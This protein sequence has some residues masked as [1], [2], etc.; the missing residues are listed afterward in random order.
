VI[1]VYGST[2]TGGIAWRQQHTAW[3]LFEGMALN[4]IDDNW[5]LHSPYLD[6][7]FSLDDN[8]SLQTDGQFML[9]GRKD[10]IV[11]IEEKRLS[12]TE[13]E[14]RLTE[15]PQIADAFTIPI[16]KNRDRVGAAIVLTEAGL[17]QLASKGRNAFIKQLRTSLYQWFDATVLPRKWLVLNSIPLTTQGK[18]NQPLI[19]ALLDTDTQKLP[20]VQSVSI[21]ANSVELTLKVPAELI[22]FPDHF[23]GYPIL[24]GV[25]QIAWAEHFG[26]LF[27]TIN[28]P[29]TMLEA[30]KFVKV[31]QPNAALTLTL[32]WND[33]TNKLYFNFCS[34]AGAHSSG[35]LG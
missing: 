34:D 5:Q 6:E 3:Q 24:P 8:L 12:L 27:F 19:N 23:A 4:C 13:L 15:L 32:T 31:I 14:Q 17:E 16:A 30:L 28:Q 20:I 11:K 7:L 21:T 9:H 25:V 1:E 33:V 10:R 2:E 35:R 22:Y 18:I 29:F 26:K